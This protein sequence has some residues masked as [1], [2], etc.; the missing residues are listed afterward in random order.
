M[1]RAVLVLVVAYFEACGVDPTS[2][3]CAPG[4]QVSCDTC[5]GG[6]VGRRQCNADGSG[7]GNCVCAP[8]DGLRSCPARQLCV[9]LSTGGS[10]VCAATCSAASD[11]SGVNSCCGAVDGSTSRACVLPPSNSGG[12]VCL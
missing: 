10:A 6:L 12:G 1:K 5:P 3:G 7:Y 2:S 4:T 11:C 9:T 8:C